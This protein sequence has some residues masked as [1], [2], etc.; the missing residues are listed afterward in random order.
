MTSKVR[1]AFPE[2]AIDVV[3]QL[4]LDE[5]CHHV[6]IVEGRRP[7]GIISHHDLVRLAQLNG[8]GHL[9]TGAYKGVTAAEIMCSD[10]ETIHLD[11][12]VESAIDRIGRGEFH[13]LVVVDDD[14]CLAGIVTSRDL[15]HYLLS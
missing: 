10:L 11:D 15:I 6:P 12:S 14:R 13:A 5:H 9:S 3:W 2:D 1:V 7:V 4:L 8:S